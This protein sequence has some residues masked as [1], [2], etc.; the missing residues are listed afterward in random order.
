MWSYLT[1]PVVCSDSGRTI[2]RQYHLQA[3]VQKEVNLLKIVYA[4]KSGAAP[5]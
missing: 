5:L 4:K 1:I 2:T 3:I